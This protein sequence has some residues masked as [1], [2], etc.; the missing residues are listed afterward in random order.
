[1][2]LSRLLR[3]AD[4]S[5]FYRRQFDQMQ[6]L[7]EDIRAYADF[8]RLPVISREDVVRFKNE[9]IAGSHRDQ[10]MHK[11]TGGSTGVPVQFALDRD[12][13]E[14]Q[15][16]VTQ[17]GYQWAGCEA[18]RHTV[19]LWGVDVGTP[20]DMRK[21]KTSLC[22][23][24]F[25]RKM[26]N[27][28]DFTEAEMRR[29][30][31][32]I[33]RNRPTGMVGFTTA[34]Y[35]F[36]R[37]IKDNGLSCQPVPAVITGAEKLYDHQ[38]ELIEEAI[39]TKVLNTYGCREFM[40]IAAECDHHQ[41]LHVSMDNLF[42]EV[43][44][45]SLPAAPGER[46]DI[47]ITDLHNYGMPFIRY[48]N[49]DLVIQGDKPCACGRSLPLILYVAG[50]R[51]DEILSTSGRAVSDGSFP[52]LMKEFQELQKFQ[53]VQKARDQLLIRVVLKQDWSQE[54]RAFCTGEIGKVLGADMRIDF[55][56]LSDIPLTKS[57]KYRVT[58]SKI[59]QSP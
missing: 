23:R 35:N 50:R 42:V 54:R 38:R 58:I 53:V 31:D 18:G 28:F 7:P 14:W 55:D 24:F 5:P 8:Q 10:I 37:F 20:S 13:Y 33:N 30:L 19:Y 39:H 4:Q 43:I 46:G 52:H 15:T 41:G 27:C 21:L 34:V 59:S 11:G 12:S 9:M 6:A 26:F 51:M 29:C 1:M 47:V 48:R 40:L 16:A 25:N 2:A 45:D 22:H 56:E 17:R 36:A 32:Y 49:G 3:H 57:G 44:T